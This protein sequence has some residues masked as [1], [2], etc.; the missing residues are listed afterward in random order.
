MAAMITEFHER[1][2][3]Q[4]KEARPHSRALSIIRSA[5]VEY[6]DFEC[7]HCGAAYP[8]IEVVREQM[9]DDLRFIYRHY[10]QAVVHAHAVRRARGG[11]GRALRAVLG[12]A[13]CCMYPACARCGEPADLRVETSARSRAVR[14]DLTH[15][16]HLVRLEDD[17]LSGT[18]SAS[19]RPPSSSTTS[20]IEDAWNAFA[21]LDALM[22]A[23]GTRSRAVGR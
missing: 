14:F 4:V 22:T 19:S 13:I 7:R 15:D 16:T 12:D 20:D 8:N 23:H 9:G 21:L 10:P 6:G 2:T 5:L 18:R 1:L 17:F 3:Q 11:S